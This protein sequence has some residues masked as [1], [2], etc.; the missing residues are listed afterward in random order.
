MVATKFGRRALAGAWTFDAV[1]TIIPGAKTVEQARANSA[2]PELPELPEAT[3]RRISELYGADRATGP[4]ALV[5][6]AAP[7]TVAQT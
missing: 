4:P 7:S 2:A 5:S 1:S 6:A 3:M